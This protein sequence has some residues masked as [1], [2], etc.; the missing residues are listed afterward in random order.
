MLLLV[1][2]EAKVFMQKL[3]QHNIWSGMSQWLKITKESG[4]TYVG[5]DIKAAMS[6]SISRQHLP[7]DNVTKQ[8][9]SFTFLL[10]PIPYVEYGAIA[11]LCVN[12]NTSFIMAKLKLELCHLSN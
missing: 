8:P 6:I 12:G 3:W 7:K 1:T 10:V 2:I 9:A 5:H 11:F 4:W